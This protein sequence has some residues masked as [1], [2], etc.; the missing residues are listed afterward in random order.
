MSAS[1]VAGPA[2]GSAPAAAGRPP[3]SA[4]RRRRWVGLLGG[5][6]LLAGFLLL[7]VMVGAKSL[8]ATDVLSVLWRPDGSEASEI[9]R[10]YRIPR[11]VIGL[12]AGAALAV[13][14]ALM[15]AVT[16][17]PLADPGLLGVNAGAGLAVAVGISVLGLDSPS[18][19]GV[20]AFLGAGT[21]TV[22]V[23]AVGRAG[24][25]AG[26]P[27]RLVLSGVALAAVFAGLSMAL[28]M[29]FPRVFAGY[30]SWTVGSLVGRDLEASAPLFPVVAAALLLA[31]ALGPALG[32]IALGEDH[33][34]AL[35]THV[36]RA[37]MLA[38]LSIT[39]LAGGATALMG[40]VVFLGLMV[41][42]AVRRFTGP[43]QPWIIASCLVYGPVVLLGADV[44][45]RLVA[46]G[47]EYPVGFM[48]ALIGAP[49]LM[50]MMTRR[51][52]LSL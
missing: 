41:P 27:A 7:S 2:G 19:Y 9:V 1:T 50:A 52:V 22:V 43:H 47:G 24:G 42:H 16:R 21:A 20:A 44:L 40:P 38:L 32:T 3:S 12:V 37:R 25:D 13:A 39:V 14:G 10:S 46:A 17:N 8:S 29:T 30:R 34:R 31:L 45:G 5:L 23:L 36:G 28:T 18:E 15:Q 49:V 48:A 4:R 6:L 11:T 33:A 51:R 35:G 26:S